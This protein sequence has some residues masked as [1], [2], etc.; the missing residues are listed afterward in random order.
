MF[1]ILTETQCQKRKYSAKTKYFEN[2]KT[3]HI[4][5]ADS[6][7]LVLICWVI[8]I[9]V[10]GK[11]FTSHVFRV[12]K[13]PRICFCISFS[14]ILLI[15]NSMISRAIWKNI[16]SWVFQRLQ[17]ALALQTHA[18]SIVFEKLFSNCTRNRPNV[19]FQQVGI[20]SALVNMF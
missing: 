4:L 5:S 1:S 19:L 2:A 7:N 8:K 17:I 9:G 6:W 11:W 15:S 3:K 16:H 18:I 20:L 12:W 13:W 10:G 14:C